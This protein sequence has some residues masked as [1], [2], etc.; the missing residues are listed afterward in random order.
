MY[1]IIIGLHGDKNP[2]KAGLIFKIYVLDKVNV[3]TDLFSGKFDD[4]R[5]L[6]SKYPNPLHNGAKIGEGI[7]FH[8]GNGDK[9][10][11]GSAGCLVNWPD[12]YW[13]LMDLFKPNEKLVLIKE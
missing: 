5:C 4:E 10:R 12:T 2:Y 7:N 8:C 1:G 13:K 6:P 3:W 9:V 11:N